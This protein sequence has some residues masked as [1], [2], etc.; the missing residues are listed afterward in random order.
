MAFW[1]TAFL[2]KMRQEWMRRIAKV[3]YQAGSTWYDAV[4]TKKEVVGNEVQI[5]TTT[6]DSANITI[7]A[8]RLIDTSGE[9]AGQRTESIQSSERRASS[10]SGNSRSTRSRAERGG[11]QLCTVGQT[12]AIMPCHRQT[13]SMCRTI[14]TAQRQSRLPVKLY[15]R[16]QT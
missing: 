1:T 3:Q 15:S 6:T 8:V 7:K 9:I 16:E 12:G 2:N 5:T 4:I 14:R 13:T 10:R 11:E